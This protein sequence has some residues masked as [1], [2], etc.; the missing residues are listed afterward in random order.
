MRGDANRRRLAQPL[1]PTR[2]PASDEGANS[3]LR[4]LRRRLG[5]RLRL[6]LAVAL[7]RQM[8]GARGSEFGFGG[9]QVGEKFGFGM[10][11]CDVATPMNRPSITSLSQ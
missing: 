5:K 8:L 4:R 9:R 7:R 11:P 6:E 3:Q 1:T 2:A 10:Q